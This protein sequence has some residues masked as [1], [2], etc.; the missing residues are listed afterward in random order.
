MQISN[1]SLYNNG[2]IVV[3]SLCTGDGYVYS[4]CVVKCVVDGMAMILLHALLIHIVQ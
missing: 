3:V 1:T 4:M 2:V